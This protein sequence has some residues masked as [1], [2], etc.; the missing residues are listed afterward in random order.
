MAKELGYETVLWSLAYVDWK[1]DQQ[2]T[3]EQAFPEAPAQD[4]PRGR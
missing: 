1:K 4:P 3:K 2:P